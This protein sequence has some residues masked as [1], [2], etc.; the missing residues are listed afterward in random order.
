MGKY[1]SNNKP[2]KLENGM[3]VLRS[4][5]QPWPLIHSKLSRF[6]EHFH[7]NNKEAKHLHEFNACLSLVI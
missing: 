5:I 7:K 4:N 1:V 2:N 3:A 6:C